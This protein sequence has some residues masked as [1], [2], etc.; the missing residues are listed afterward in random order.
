[1]IHEDPHDKIIIVM[2]I[3][4]TEDNDDEQEEESDIVD[5]FICYRY[6]CHMNMMKRRNE[7]RF[8]VHLNLCYLY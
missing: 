1:M 3:I 5:D 6:P 4:L 2:I 7:M 8:F